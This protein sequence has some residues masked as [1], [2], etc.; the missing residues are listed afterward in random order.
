MRT[1]QKDHSPKERVCQDKYDWK[2]TNTGQYENY[3][4]KDEN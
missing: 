4:T 2:K 3:A 1:Q